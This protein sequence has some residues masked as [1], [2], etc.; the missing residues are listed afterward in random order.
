MPA[1]IR[2]GLT[3]YGERPS[4]AIGN[5]SLRVSFDKGGA[6]DMGIITAVSGFSVTSDSGWY[7][8]TGQVYAQFSDAQ[9]AA[10]A[11]KAAIAVLSEQYGWTVYLGA[12]ASAADASANAS[13]ATVS[14]AQPNRRLLLSDGGTPA[15]LLDFQDTYAQFSDGTGGGT[16][17]LGGRK[18]RGALECRPKG[19]NVT[20]VN[21]LTADEYLYGVVPSEMPQG[22]PLEALKAQAVASR[23]YMSTRLGVHSGD[24]YDFCDQGHCQNYLGADN[25]AASAVRA[26]DATSG[27]MAYYD[28]EPINAV[29][30][31]SSGGITEDSENV[32]PNAMPYLRGVR[33][34][35]DEAYKEWT[36]VFTLAELDA[37]LSANNAGIGAAVGVT[38]GAATPGG[39][40]SELIINGTAGR[41]SLYK[42][43]IRTF[44]S[45]S[46]GGPLE[47]RNFILGG[48]DSARPEAAESDTINIMGL[49]E[50]PVQG[51]R[52]IGG[53]AAVAA[54]TEVFVAGS[55][56]TRRYGGAS[57][58]SGTSGGA[59]RNGEIVFT[60]KGSGHGVGMSQ[61]GAKAMAEAG[62]TYA[63]ILRH[64]YTGIEVR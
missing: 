19:A 1:K 17:S 24:G 59:G 4:V 31:A 6:R 62:Y 41:K 21:I 14:G 26:V 54:L 53:G 16:V 11:Y 51:L 29:Y 36:R 58:A 44:F 37:V 63:Q 48:I 32:W 35:A 18:Y 7:V 57:Q 27:I 56:T 64:Y 45:V 25:E 15:V 52:V 8:A 34:I 49:G 55:G 12:F 30:F 61:Y 20:V 38:I 3:A 2:V 10:A 43:E 47:S 13:G 5:K 46:T 40:V 28:G 39:R 50:Y 22:W 9:A 33:E 42:E 60:G 23:S